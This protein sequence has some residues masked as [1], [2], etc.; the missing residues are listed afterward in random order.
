VLVKASRTRLDSRRLV[1]EIDITT[2]VQYALLASDGLWEKVSAATAVRYINKQ[3]SRGIEVGEITKALVR[4]ALAKGSA[5]NITVMLVV[6]DHIDKPLPKPP[7]RARLVPGAVTTT[8]SETHESIAKSASSMNKSDDI[9]DVDEPS[10]SSDQ[11]E[12]SGWT[13]SDYAVPIL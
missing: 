5:D 10:E 12:K 9:S 11:V 7:L 4:Q 13:Q 6:F 3:L 1:Q 8:N 2:E